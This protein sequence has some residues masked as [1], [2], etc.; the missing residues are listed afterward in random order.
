[1]QEL[2]VEKKIVELFTK[3]SA[4]E[5]ESGKSIA[6]LEVAF[7]T[8]GTLSKERDNAVLICHALT[9]DSHVA[10][11]YSVT[12]KKGG[13]WDSMVGPGKTFDT[14]KY[15]IICSNV[16]GGCKGSTGPASINPDT[17]KEYASTFPV[18]TIDDMVRV[19]KKL[20]GTL[21]IDKLLCVVG[22]SMGGMQALSWSILYPE[23][24]R[25]AVIIASAA[26]TSAQAIAFNKVG[27][28]AITSDPNWQEGHY[29]GAKAPE[30]GL[31]IARMIGHITYL[32]DE[33]M[34]KKFSRNLQSRDEVSFEL[35]DEFAVES[36]LEHQGGVFVER[37]DANTYL[38]ITKAMDYYDLPGKYGSMDAA[39]RNI[40]AK[41]LIVSFSS[42][43]LFPPYQSKEIVKA[44]MRNQKDVSYC[45]IESSYGHD[46]FL[47][48]VDKLGRI[49]ESFLATAR[50]T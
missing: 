43:W 6:P 32:S 18:F 25:S 1:M 12:D 38:Y 30:K 49:I 39:V 33:S 27:R 42:D 36:Y 23:T 9:G 35:A 34:R 15:F 19:Q 8:L 11:K 44:L 40:A 46:A 14:D 50:K 10:G 28:N 48:E 16:I 24:V 17:G 22:G 37:F 4:F 20:I 31:S 2:I 29:Y 3:E 41:M 47:L 13:W 21:E 45:A 7:E 5:L 26:Y